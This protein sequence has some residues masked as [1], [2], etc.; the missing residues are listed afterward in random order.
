MFTKLI[1]NSKKLI[2]M[3]TIILTAVLVIT[4]VIVLNHNRRSKIVEV[5]EAYTMYID[6]GAV[7]R[8]TFDEEYNKCYTKNE[9]YKIC[10][11]I[12]TKVLSQKLINNSSKEIYTNIDFVG[13]NIN[14][15]LTLLVDTA[16]ENDLDFDN[17]TITLDSSHLN[18][19]KILN[20]LNDNLSYSFNG[21]INIIYQEYIDEN[22]I[23]IKDIP[24][25]KIYLV[26]FDSNGG[27]KIDNQ[28]IKENDKVVKPEDPVRE[29]YTFEGWQ[30][31]TEDFDFNIKIE[32]DIVLKA[33]WSKNV[34]STPKPSQN[35]NNNNSNNNNNN[36]N[37]N[38]KPST[39]NPSVD[40]Q[41]QE[42]NES[43]TPSVNPEEIIPD[44]GQSVPK[45]EEEEN[46]PVQEPDGGE[47]NKD[48]SNNED[49]TNSEENNN[50]T[51]NEE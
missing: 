38:Q 41:S 31:D 1:Q 8:L 20:F 22:S 19:E 11:D 32:S 51:Q 34:V 16:T 33:K 35:N 49:I 39:S 24:E 44:N 7:V 26:T 23:D 9:D 40:N 28:L 46:P 27:S 15:A 47:T 13:K 2:I 5:K 43:T 29:G 10:S 3:I 18:K 12:S 42:G 21:D 37:N 30:L 14:E 4:E 36:S 6:L 48:N 17:I 45:D 50:T 25:E